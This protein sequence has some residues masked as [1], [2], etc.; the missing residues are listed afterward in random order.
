MLVNISETIAGNRWNRFALLTEHKFCRKLS[1]S[2]SI[3]S[4]YCNRFINLG[5]PILPLNHSDASVAMVFTIPTTF[6][7]AHGQCYTRAERATQSA[8]RVRSSQL[9]SLTVLWTHYVPKIVFP[10]SPICRACT[11]SIAIY[12]IIMKDFIFSLHQPAPAIRHFFW[13]VVIAGDGRQRNQPRDCAMTW[14]FH[15]LQKICRIKVS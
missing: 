1:R 15:V 2:I 5:R 7:I 13:L 8:I 9:D 11:N 14:A 3:D 4:R 6:G 10:F 12:L